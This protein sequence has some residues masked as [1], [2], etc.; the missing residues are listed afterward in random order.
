MLGSGIIDCV[1]SNIDAIGIM[2]LNR[3]RDSVTELYECVEVPDCL[4]GCSGKYH[5]CCFCG[6]AGNGLLFL[7]IGRAHV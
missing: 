6:R 1:L 4:T 5:I 2:C 3:D 7:K